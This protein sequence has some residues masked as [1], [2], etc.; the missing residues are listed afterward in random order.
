MSYT[1]GEYI[2][3]YILNIGFLSTMNFKI[4]K[5]QHQKHNPNRKWAKNM[6]RY[7]IKQEI[8]IAHKHMKICSHYLSLQKCKL[9][10]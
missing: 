2:A 7:F 10:P 1:L 6:N 3:N 4:L 5:A 8:M 9:K